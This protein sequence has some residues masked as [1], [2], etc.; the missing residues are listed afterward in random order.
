MIDFS[1]HT[2]KS[3]S[4]DMNRFFVKMVKGLAWVYKGC[5]RC[6]RC[7]QRQI[8]N[9]D[10]VIHAAIDTIDDTLAEHREGLDHL[11]TRMVD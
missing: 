1:S 7:F 8:E 5:E 6:K 10:T 11:T 2:G 3:V 4:D 9:P